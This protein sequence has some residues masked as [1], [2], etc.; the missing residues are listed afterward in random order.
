MD[1]EVNQK[2]FKIKGIRLL[3][4]G[5]IIMVFLTTGCSAN[6][7]E[8]IRPTATTDP[9]ESGYAIL[10]YADQYREVSEIMIRN[11]LEQDWSSLES[12]IE[13]GIKIYN[14]AEKLAVTSRYSKAK[15]L[16]CNWM[17]TDSYYYALILENASK[18]KILTTGQASMD[19]FLYFIEEMEK[20][21]HVMK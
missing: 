6:V 1:S 8:Q 3:A 16:M 5:L 4:L 18:D 13:K 14:S 9:Y 17:V 21:G 7:T 10:D 2:K 19:F 12:Q 15:E 20:L 11:F